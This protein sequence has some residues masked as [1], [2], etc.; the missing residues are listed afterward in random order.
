MAI[1]YS[2]FTTNYLDDYASSGKAPFSSAL[3]QILAKTPDDLTQQDR[4]SI[5]STFDRAIYSSFTSLKSDFD[6]FS[7]NYQFLIAQDVIDGFDLSD[8]TKSG[9]ST[10]LSDLTEN[11]LLA[12][13]SS[14]AQALQDAKRFPGYASKIL[15]SA[16][17]TR[18]G[19]ELTIL[20]QNHLETADSNLLDNEKYFATLMK[21]SSSIELSGSGEYRDLF[22]YY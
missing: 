18:E 1:P 22:N 21:N 2:G 12:N 3:E 4:A 13:S 19:I 7:A 6:I 10:L 9:L 14:L 17:K 15:A 20:L 16:E 5:R 8:E 11:N